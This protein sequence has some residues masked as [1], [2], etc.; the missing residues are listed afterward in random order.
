MEMLEGKKAASRKNVL[1]CPVLLLCER[2]EIA[3]F[4][5]CYIR[6]LLERGCSIAKAQVINL[7]RWEE[8]PRFLQYVAK[9][10][11]TEL[12]Q[13]VR[14]LADAGPSTRVKQLHLEKIKN[15][16]FLRIFPDFAYYLF[17]GKE[18]GRYW[19]KGYL[20]DVLLKN[21]RRESSENA[22]FENL[23]NITQDFLLSINSCR[24]EQL[25]LQN[26]SRHTLHAFFAGTEKYVGM[27]MGEAFLQG[28][29]A[30]GEGLTGLRELLEAL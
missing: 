8:L 4:V 29:F 26:H 16:S 22:V 18:G 10:E 5:S 19:R 30:E 11:H 15:D 17:P 13:K 28:A 23:F 20:E 21:L 14:L 9:H 1:H 24:G 3:D 2:R 7:G 25:H 12:L 27:S 6:F